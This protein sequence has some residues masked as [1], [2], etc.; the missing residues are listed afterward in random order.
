MKKILER[1]AADLSRPYEKCLQYGPSVLNDAELLAVVIRSGTRGK[2]AV[3]LAKQI[4]AGNQ[5]GK[6]LLGLLHMSMA[7]LTEIPGIGEVKAIQLKCIAELSRRISSSSAET[8]LDFGNPGSVAEYYMESLRHKEQEELVLVML[9]TKCHRISDAVIF[10]GTV[11]ASLV[12]T[13][14]LFLA[15]IRNRAVQIILL[16]NHPSGDPTPSEE[17]IAVTK[18]VAEAGKLLDIHLVDHIVI[19]DRCYVSFRESKLL[20]F[21]DF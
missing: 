20:R 16:H 13:R 12:S 7:D 9:D 21:E 14:E 3:E 19:G 10:T 18:K 1:P 5:T 6:G 2:S 4:L 11:N 17:D 8:G 15:A